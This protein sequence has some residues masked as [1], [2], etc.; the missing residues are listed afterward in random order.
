[1]LDQLA[2]DFF[3]EIAAIILILLPLPGDEPSGMALAASAFSFDTQPLAKP[4]RPESSSAAQSLPFRAPRG[5]SVR[6][7]WEVRQESHFVQLKRVG[8]LAEI[9]LR[10]GFNAKCLTPKCN[11]VHVERQDLLLVQRILNAIGEDRLL[12]LAGIAIFVG[13]Q[14]VLSPPAA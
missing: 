8:A 10:C 9:G 3:G 13:Q 14:Q 12:D 11:L 1:L 7:P 4:F 5:Y 6:G 2:A